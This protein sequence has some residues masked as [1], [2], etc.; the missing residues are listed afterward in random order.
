[1]R[2]SLTVVLLTVAWAS[3]ANAEC[4]ASASGAFS[5]DVRLSPLAGR[6][7]LMDVTVFAGPSC[8][9]ARRQWSSTRGCNETD[10]MAVTD[11]GDL[12]SILAPATSHR[13]WAIVSVIEWRS[14]RVTAAT[15][16]LQDL[17]GA[18]TLRGVVRPVFDGAAIRL[19]PDVLVSFE[20]LESIPAP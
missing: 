13:D 16:A 15:L 14:G 5:F 3:T 4:R 11:R 7:C 12:V 2:P 20:T 8:E 10:R 19:A 1:M 6:A 18:G 9:P 17:P